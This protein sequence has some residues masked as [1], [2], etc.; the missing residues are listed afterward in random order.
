M[1]TSRGLHRQAAHRRRI[2]LLA[3][4][5]WVTFVVAIGSLGLLSTAANPSGSADV[6]SGAAIS[7]ARIDPVVASAEEAL[8]EKNPAES[9]LSESAPP[10]NA[11]SAVNANESEAV[12]K[13][14]GTGKRV[15]FS[16]AAQRVWLVNADESVK[17]TYQ[18][19]GGIGD[20]L[21]VGSYKVQ[22][23]FRNAT[24]YDYGSTMQYFVRFTSGHNAPIGFH[25][26]PIG[27]DG[28]MLQTLDQLGTP[29]SSGCI[30]QARPD[31]VELWDF[32]PVGSR[33][34][35]LG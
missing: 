7:T 20:N 10:E 13:D 11:Q 17:R 4:T 32:A 3:T 16:L 8:A 15:V 33:V 18:A 28:K 12:P 31:A 9:A 2:G 29:L 5:S 27:H 1:P 34:E 24:S 25:D 21:R 19:S 22:S 14:S 26:I 23:K 35:V 30:R 6:V